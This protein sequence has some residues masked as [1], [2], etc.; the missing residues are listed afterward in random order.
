MVRNERG[1]VGSRESKSQKRVD[2]Q[3]MRGVAVLAVLLFHGN[4]SW[5]SNGYLGVDVFFV[6]SGFVVTPLLARVFLQETPTKLFSALKSFYR[7]RFYRLA[8]ALGTTLIGSAFLILSLGPVLDHERFAKQGLSTL[9]LLG[10]IGAYHYSGGDYFAPNPN[11]LVHT[12][13]LSAE[14]QIYLVLPLIF[15]I[16]GL[17]RKFRSKN[18]FKVLI[19]AVGLAAYAL[20]ASL[21][22]FPD[23]LHHF[24]ITNVSQFEFYSPI[25]RLWEF[26]IGGGAYFAAMRVPKIK[27]RWI[28]LIATLIL[29]GILFLP[30]TL[31]GFQGL[32]VCTL[33]ALTLHFRVLELLPEKANAVMEW[34]GDRSYS[35]YLVHMPIVYVAHFSTLFVDVP[36]WFMTTTATVIAIYCGSLSYRHIEQRFR[37]VTQD[38]KP[39]RTSL[40]VLIPTFVLVPALVFV[41]I[42][43]GVRSNYWQTN[44]NGK[45]PVDAGLLD[46]N[47]ERMNSTTPCS[48]PVDN[49]K[50]EAL[51]IGDSHAGAISEAFITSMK[52]VHFSSYV[53]SKGACQ[54]IRI[55]DLNPK[56]VKILRYDEE[57]VL[58]SQ[59]CEAHNA[60]IW[61][62]V[63][64]HPKAI[65]FVNVRSS[66]DRP[67]AMPA[68]T[69]RELLATNLIDLSSLAKRLI[70]IGPSPEFPDS[71]A[72]FSSPRLLWQLSEP[73][74]RDYPTIRMDRN[75]FQDDEYFSQRFRNTK[76]EYQ[77]VKTI[78]CSSTACSR[79]SNLGWLYRDGNHLSILGA[80]RLSPLLTKL[81]NS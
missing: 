10:N 46:P 3:V 17:L 15:V 37:I 79:W 8:P 20:D 61:S 5:F 4:E 53:W 70:F 48:Y 33:T 28:S 80:E 36:G 77:S 69:F 24:G 38:E 16:F 42:S 27:S 49:P 6:I 21:I 57:L 40:K 68:L 35:T 25:S 58:G 64:Q 29:A 63:K 11:P 44:A 7:R 26:C 39:G 73:Y 47:C 60:D 55:Q 13:S 18:F 54:P 23:F 59:S 50:G 56:D 81:I 66:S 9:L 51:L 67:S 45:Q 72:F 41:A 34:L 2:I 76:V 22:A 75:S 65:V 43:V 62:W 71:A 78:F 30:V 32:I 1:L 74:P 19:I 52:T 12:W 14:E 31:D